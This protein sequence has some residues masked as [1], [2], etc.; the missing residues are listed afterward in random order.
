MSVIKFI[1][2]FIY[3]IYS[4]STLARLRRWLKLQLISAEIEGLS[5]TSTI[6]SRG[7][8]YAPFLRNR[9]LK[10]NKQQVNSISHSLVEY[11]SKKYTDYLGTCKVNIHSI[12]VIFGPA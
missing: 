5:I 6:T 7:K 2:L 3:F 4:V 12:F 11:Y 1:S 10:V 9:R 8:N